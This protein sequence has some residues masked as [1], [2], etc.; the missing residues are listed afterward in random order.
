MFLWS[1]KR[2][3]M[4]TVCL[5]SSPVGFSDW[6]NSQFFPSNLASGC[7]DACTRSPTFLQ[8]NE[9]RNSRFFTQTQLRGVFFRYDTHSGLCALLQETQIKGLAATRH[10]LLSTACQFTSISRCKLCV[11]VALLCTHAS[12]HTLCLY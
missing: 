6:P 9:R 1:L 10:G 8:T 4:I 7:S 3:R 12:H 11:D 5:M 2:N